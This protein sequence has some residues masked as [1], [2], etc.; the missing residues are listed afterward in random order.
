MDA[1]SLAGWARGC[2]GFFVLFLATAGGAGR[3]AH[4]CRRLACVRLLRIADDAIVARRSQTS[5]DDVC[6]TPGKLKEKS[7]RRKSRRVSGKRD[8]ALPQSEIPRYARNDRAALGMRCGWRIHTVAVAHTCRR[9][10]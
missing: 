1:N 9:S 5:Q 10:A 6:A 4:T 8:S 7:E 3:V 2:Q